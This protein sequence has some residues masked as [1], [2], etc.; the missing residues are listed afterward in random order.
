KLVDERRDF[1]RIARAKDVSVAR[2]LQD[3]TE[4]AHVRRLVVDD[5]NPA[6]PRPNTVRREARRRSKIAAPSRRGAAL[7]WWI[8]RQRSRHKILSLRKGRWAAR[9]G[10]LWRVVRCRR[11]TQVSWK[12][13]D[14]RRPGSLGFSRCG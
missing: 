14:E 8:A 9:D 10:G 6:A 13:T 4:Q 1:S 11:A 3:A 2:A 7:V 5:E 12:T